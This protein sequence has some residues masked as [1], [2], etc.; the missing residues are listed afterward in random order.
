ML[1]RAASSSP[2]SARPSRPDAP[3]EGPEGRGLAS[4][5]WESSRASSTSAPF[6]A[7]ASPSRRTSSPAGPASRPRRRRT[8][9]RWRRSASRSTRRGRMTATLYRDAGLRRRRVRLGD[10]R[11]APRPA[12]RRRGV[13]ATGCLARRRGLDP[14]ARARAAPR[15][16]GPRPAGRRRGPRERGARGARDGAD[17]RPEVVRRRAAARLPAPGA[18]ASRA[19]EAPRPLPPRHDGARRPA[20]ARVGRPC[21]P[22]LRSRSTTYPRSSSAAS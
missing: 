1:E 14:A 8:P 5:T 20:D 15:G 17:A 2:A 18:T 19:R 3:R 11:R 10:G 4:G 16:L 22:R 12:A 7:A 13:R 6:P 21:E 9:P